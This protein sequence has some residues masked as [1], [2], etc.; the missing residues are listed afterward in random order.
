M[1]GEKLILE[2]QSG[3]LGAVKEL[4]A[5]GV[6]PDVTDRYGF[7]ALMMA[8]LWSRATVA[9]F[10]LGIGASTETREYFF[11]CTALT[12]ACLSGTAE[13]VELLL[14]SGAEVNATDRMGR[15]PLMAASSVG[16]FEAV[17]LLLKAGAHV[18]AE[19][20]FGVTAPDLAAIEGHTKVTALLLPPSSR[21]RGLRHTSSSVPS[22]CCSG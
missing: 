16:N 3:N 5:A 18:Q 2:A 12:F 13:V 17:K 9:K 10:L 6:D 15:T 4:L 11:G 14:K 20:K 19:D 22:A 8:S 21:G 1:F 7:T